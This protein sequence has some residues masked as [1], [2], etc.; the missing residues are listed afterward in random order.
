MVRPKPQRPMFHRPRLRALGLISCESRL[1]LQ[2]C[3]LGSDSKLFKPR[4]AVFEL[5]NDNYFNG[6]Q[7]YCEKNKFYLK[8]NLCYKTLFPNTGHFNNR[9]AII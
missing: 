9:D 4:L 5:M 6:F 8:N 7:N 1:R 2:V 3:N